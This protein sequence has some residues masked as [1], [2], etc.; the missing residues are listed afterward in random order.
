MDYYNVNNVNEDIKDLK[1]NLCDNDN[2]VEFYDKNKNIICKY[3]LFPDNFFSCL[4]DG[5]KIETVKDFKK[6][7]NLVDHFELNRMYSSKIFNFRKGEFLGYVKSLNCII[8]HKLPDISINNVEL[9]DDISNK[10]TLLLDRMLKI[11]NRL[12]NEVE[13]PKITFKQEE[14]NSQKIF[15]QEE[16]KKPHISD[17]PEA[18][19]NKV[20]KVLIDTESK[21][22][23][24]F[25]KLPKDKDIKLLTKEKIKSFNTGRD[26]VKIYS[27]IKFYTKKD[28]LIQ[29][30]SELNDSL[31]FSSSIPEDKIVEFKNLL[32]EYTDYKEHGDGYNNIPNPI[33]KEIENGDNIN[34]FNEFIEMITIQSNISS[35]INFL[36]K[37]C[38]N[39]T[40][41]ENIFFMKG[42]R[43]LRDTINSY[44]S[45][46]PS[47]SSSPLTQ[48]IRNNNN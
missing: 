27:I 47:S 45:S 12:F 5:Y 24:N 30:H 3:N 41:K 21:I 23:N 11:E 19:Y 22:L 9:L 39:D 26:A 20:E 17:D 40:Y 16:K 7:K 34:E 48:S 15:K 35:I 29:L 13:D 25:D 43:K 4:K 10:Y 8:T 33:M 32:R 38:S 42:I 18:F 46:S 37:T 44:E 1:F 2:L 36:E 28:Q 14:P 31:S 6:I